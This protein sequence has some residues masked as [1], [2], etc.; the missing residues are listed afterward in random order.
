[1]V[2]VCGIVVPSVV[3]DTADIEAVKQTIVKAAKTNFKFNDCCNYIFFV[4]PFPYFRID[5][6]E[7]IDENLK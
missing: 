7:I 4:S 6:R 1:L 3:V 5:T 2:L